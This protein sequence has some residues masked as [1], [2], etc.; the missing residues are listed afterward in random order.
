[1]PSLSERLVSRR[2]QRPFFGLTPGLQALFTASAAGEGTIPP[3]FRPTTLPEVPELPSDATSD[4][5]SARQQRLERLSQLALS[6]ERRRTPFLGT[7][8]PDVV[9]SP[10]AGGLTDLVTL[11]AQS[12]GNFNVPFGT[13]PF[14]SDLALFSLTQSGSGG[15]GGGLNANPASPGTRFPTIINPSLPGNPARVTQGPQQSGGQQANP[16]FGIGPATI[17]SMARLQQPPQSSVPA[18]SSLRT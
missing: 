1:M 7:N 16:L 5:I 6:R 14:V 10:T 13:G 15:V 9:R 11:A 17:T 3:A 18:T 4:Q 8:V 12:G 2:R